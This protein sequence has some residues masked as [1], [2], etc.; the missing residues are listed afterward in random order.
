M[1]GATFARECLRDRGGCL[2][3]YRSSIAASMLDRPGRTV[4][5]VD[6]M[7]EQAKKLGMVR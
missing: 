5:L 1:H 6:D 3:G 7:F 2:S 4:V